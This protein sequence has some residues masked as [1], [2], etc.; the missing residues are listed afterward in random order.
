MTLTQHLWFLVCVGIAS[1]AQNL[2]GFAFSLLLLGL[3]GVL[4]LAPL[5]DVTTWPVCSRS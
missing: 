3:A 1:Y 2:T 4:D 5:A